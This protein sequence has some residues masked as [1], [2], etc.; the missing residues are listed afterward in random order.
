MAKDKKAFTL[1]ADMIH[2]FR[3][4]NNEQ[5]G[6]IFKHL[7]AYVNDENPTFKDPMLEIVFEPIKQILKR[8]L[9]K[10]EKRCVQNKENA[11]K[12]NYANDANGINGKPNDANHA[13]KEKDKEKDKEI[14]KVTKRVKKKVIIPS[15][16]EFVE[17]AQ[18]KNPNVLVSHVKSKYD[19]W[20]ENGWKNGN[21][22]PIKIWK[23]HLSGVITYLQENPNKKQ[24]FR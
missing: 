6:A 10:Y 16:E 9:V 17:Y 12:R 19:A 4:L 24:I 20:V 14:T 5:A 18:S 7:L 21:D 2:T 22:K 13:E 11:N 15:L 8:D 1:Y 23:S 3:L